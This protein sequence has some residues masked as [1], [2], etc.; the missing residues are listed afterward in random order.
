METENMSGHIDSS[1]SSKIKCGKIFQAL[2]NHSDERVQ[3]WAKHKRIPWILS[4]IN[5]CYSKMQAASFD[6]Y[7]ENSN[8][9]ESFHHYSN[10]GGIRQEHIDSGNSHLAESPR[11]TGAWQWTNKI[12]K[13]QWMK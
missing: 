9:I 3:A 6:S 13:R 2:L 5:R 12:C 10:L 4:G 1:E 8:L 11:P 7:Q